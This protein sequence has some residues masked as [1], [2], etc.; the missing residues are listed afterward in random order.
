MLDELIRISFCVLIL[1]HLVPIYKYIKHN[2]PSDL[3]SDFSFIL[4]LVVVYGVFCCI[5]FLF[6]LQKFLKKEE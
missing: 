6:E 4:G 2:I 1:K 5:G 3:A